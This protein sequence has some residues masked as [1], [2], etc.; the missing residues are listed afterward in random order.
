[1]AG[2]YDDFLRTNIPRGGVF[3]PGVVLYELHAGATTRADRVDIETIRPP[4]DHVADALIAV[5]AARPNAT[6]AAE[7]IRGMTRWAWTLGRLGTRIRV[8]PLAP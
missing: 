8:Q 4:R 7:D 3:V 1:M 5:T 6:V 2:W